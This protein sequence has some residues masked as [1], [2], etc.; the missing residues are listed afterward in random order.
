MAKN[1]CRQTNGKKKNFFLIKLLFSIKAYS[2]G[3]SKLPNCLSY[4]LGP[5]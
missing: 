1:N 3:E 5:I 2:Q 4:I